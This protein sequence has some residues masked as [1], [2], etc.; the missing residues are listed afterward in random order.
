MNRL[1]HSAA[2]LVVCLSMAGCGTPAPAPTG[3]ASTLV[4]ALGTVNTVLGTLNATPS[5]QNVIG[6]VSGSLGDAKAALSSFNSSLPGGGITVEKVKG[7]CGFDNSLHTLAQLVLPYVPPPVPGINPVGLDNLAYAGIQDAC[8]IA[9]G[10][11]L[12]SLDAVANL[13]D[14]AKRGTAALGIKL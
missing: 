2:A 7:V 6:W 3:A 14:V 4:S 9:T 1:K 5:G 11:S 8:A 12:P 10:G 13:V